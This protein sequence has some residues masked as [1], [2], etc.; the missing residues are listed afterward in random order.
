MLVLAACS[1][2]AADVS[3]VEDANEGNAEPEDVA[4]GGEIRIAMG[5]LP[6]VLDPVQYNTPPNNFVQ[7]ML[8]STLTKVNSTGDEVVI[9]PYLAESWEHVDDLVWEFYLQ[10]GLEF[11]NGEPLDAE[12]VV[13]STEFVLDPDSNKAM[14]SRINTIEKIEAVDETTV[15]ITTTDADPLLPSRMGA[16]AIMPPGDF[17]KRGEE[18]F[19][20]D[21]IGTGP[22]AVEEFVPGQRLVVVPNEHSAGPTP[23]L[24]SMEFEVIPESGSRISALRA[25]D[26]DVVHRLPTEQIESVEGDGYQVVGQVESGTYNLTMV[27]EDGPLAD[28]QVRRA[29]QYAIDRETINDRILAGLGETASQLVNPGFTGYCEDIEPL[30]Y[31][32]ERAREMLADAGYPDGFEVDMQASRGFLVNDDT[33]AEAVAGYLTEVGVKVNLDIME[34][35]PFLD[36]FYDPAQRTGLYAWRVSA[37]PFLDAD[38][39]MSFWLSEDPV[40][41]AP[42]SNK[43]YDDL[44]LEARQELDEDRRQELL[45]DATEVLLEDAPV[46]IMLHLPDV[47]AMTDEI[48]NFQI[49]AYGVPVFH[50]VGLSQ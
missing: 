34:Y 19:L 37:N 49:E 32:P 12:A 4:E 6:P 20:S 40:H 3:P 23:N 26:V 8:F 46:L 7:D 43:Q 15:R 50:D 48:A 1:D 47:W 10:K 29:L 14:A 21:P 35:G 28:P 22:F 38:L 33:L 25:G 39:S 13:W 5:A 24:D 44:F 36:A 16:L 30:P 9:E 2:D 41:R 27:Q 45:C 42:Y 17:K 31:D 18:E 11:P